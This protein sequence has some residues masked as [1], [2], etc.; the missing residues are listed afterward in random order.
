MSYRPIF[1]TILTYDQVFFVFDYLNRPDAALRFNHVRQQIRLQLTYI[2]EDVIEPTWRAQAYPQDLEYPIGQGMPDI[3]A[4]WDQ[5]SADFFTSLELRSQQWLRRTA[6][7][8][9]EAYNEIEGRASP[10]PGDEYTLHTTEEV[11]SELMLMLVRIDELHFPPDTS[12]RTGSKRQVL[13]AADSDVLEID[14]VV[15]LHR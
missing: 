14:G 13:S 9:R 12:G 2:Q 1:N 4:W 11:L 6:D 10:P 5:W 8:V 15:S 3:V 7:H